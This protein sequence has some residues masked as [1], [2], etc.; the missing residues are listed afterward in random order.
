MA[1]REATYGDFLAALDPKPMYS[2]MQP[3]GMDLELLE[4]AGAGGGQLWAHYENV[5][6]SAPGVH[7]FVQVVL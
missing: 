1:E 2:G 7:C 4:Q 6:P 3:G 5:W